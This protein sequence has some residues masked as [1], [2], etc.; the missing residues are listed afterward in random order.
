MN[1]I[2]LDEIERIINNVNPKQV[3]NE[4]GSV[5]ISFYFMKYVYTTVRGHRKEGIKYLL[6]DELNPNLN[7]QQ[8]LNDWVKDFNKN[9]SYRAVSN[10]KFLE[11]S[12]IGTI[13]I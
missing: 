11:G 7:L 9:N 8:K 1:V 3:I 6:T 4:L 10:V 13:L 12:C 2:N 5:R